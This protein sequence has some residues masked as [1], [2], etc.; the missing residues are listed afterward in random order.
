[1]MGLAIRIE[2][3][4]SFTGFD[5]KR[6]FRRLRAHAVAIASDPHILRAVGDEVQM[7]LHQIIEQSAS[8]PGVQATNS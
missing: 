3:A 4:K 6:S 7:R 1:M 5:T 8:R 2:L